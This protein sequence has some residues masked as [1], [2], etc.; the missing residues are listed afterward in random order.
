MTAAPSPAP[1]ILPP[2]DRQDF[3][4]RIGALAADIK[5][6]HSVFA[7]P[8]AILA[9][10]MAAGGVPRAGQIVLIVT[11]MVLARTAAM[12][13]NR[14]FDAELD[15]VNPRTAKRAIPAGRLSKSFV[16]AATLVCVAGFVAVTSLF[17][18]IYSNWI[19]LAASLPVLAF[20]CAYPFV[21][22]FSRLC[23]YWLG[24]ALG[25]APLCAWLAIAGHFAWEPVLMGAAVLLWTA[26][27]D[28]LYAC[29]DFASDRATGVHSMPADTG[30]TPALWIA[31]FSHAL[32]LGLLISLG[33][34]SPQLGGVYFAAVAVTGL[35]LVVEHAVVKPTDL[36]KINLA[37]FTI[38]GFISLLLGTAGVV[39]VLRHASL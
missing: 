1:D 30:V 3:V 18:V 33:R 10:F 36:S 4:S 19:P 8:W 11:C 22:R 39:D 34:L 32:C 17:G 28:I 12:S 24:T 26:G 27:F 16:A 5:L 14:L 23:H 29:Q 15:R 13:A 35:L 37:F 31:R 21:K 7:L 9:T 38:N 25:L 2:A 6:S 20:I